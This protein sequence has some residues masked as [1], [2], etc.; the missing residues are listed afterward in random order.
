MT[1]VFLW[2]LLAYDRVVYL[3]PRSLIQKNPD[4]LFACEGFCAAGAVPSIP[5]PFSWSADSAPVEVDGQ[6]S[7]VPPWQPSTSV[8][9]LEPS[10]EVHVA[11]LDKLTRTPD[12]GSLEAQAFLSSFLGAAGNKCDPFDELEPGGKR[13]P[14]VPVGAEKKSDRAVGGVGGMSGAVSGWIVVERGVGVED[15]LGSGGVG[16]GGGGG[17]GAVTGDV[18]M[19]KVLLNGAAKLPRCTAKPE[20]TADGKCHKL[21]YTYAAP[22]S[23]LHAKSDPVVRDQVRGVYPLSKTLLR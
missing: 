16:G 20:R 11:M 9:V 5:T 12:V 4:A 6:E 23:H 8:M 15:G 1:K 19:P 18:F 2:N 7:L 21:P 17:G 14:P 10:M 13:L 22:S 3:D